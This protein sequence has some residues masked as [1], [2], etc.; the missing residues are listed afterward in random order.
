[1]AEA[2][3]ASSLIVVGAGSGD[4]RRSVNAT[5]GRLRR[6]A[7]LTTGSRIGTRGRERRYSLAW[8]SAQSPWICSE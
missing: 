2:G 5:G 6:Q 3:C 7:Y 1:M 4:A 8:Q